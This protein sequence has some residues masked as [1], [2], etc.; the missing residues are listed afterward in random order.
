MAIEELIDLQEAGVRARI[1]GLA[2][3]ENPFIRADKLPSENHE[4]WAD[5]LSR[6]D[7]W[8]FGWEVENASREGNLLP[9]VRNQLQT[10]SG[11]QP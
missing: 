4:N 8:K 3:N 1:L 6:H 9:L 11:P 2:E 5:W 7:A 10:A